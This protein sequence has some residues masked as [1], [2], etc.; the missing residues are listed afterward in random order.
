NFTRSAQA[1]ADAQ[2]RCRIVADK[3]SADISNSNGARSESLL[4]STT[5]NGNPASIPQNALIVQVPRRGS[6][7]NATPQFIEV[8]L[9]YVKMD[10]LKAAEG[11]A[12]AKG[13]G[14][15][16]INP[17]NGFEDPTLT[18]PKGQPVLPVGM[19]PT[20]VRYFVALRDPF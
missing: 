4:V 2:A 16:Y 8:S 15:G 14:G 20:I 7:T 10:L 9:P 11:D 3:I 13:P 19:G 1:F 6:T 18:A 17:V 5:L 12:S